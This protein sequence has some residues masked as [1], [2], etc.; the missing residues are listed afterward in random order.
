MVQLPDAAG[1]PGKHL[2]LRL[3]ASWEEHAILRFALLALG[4]D[5]RLLRRLDPPAI[6]RASSLAQ[7]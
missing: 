1:S 2:R 5:G 6:Y 7:S 3:E 4:P